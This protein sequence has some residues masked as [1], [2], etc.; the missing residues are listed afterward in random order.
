MY[1][2]DTIRAL[3]AAVKAGNLQGVVEMLAKGADFEA[4]DSFQVRPIHLAAG[5]GHLDIL[6]TLIERG[7]NV[8]AG[9]CIITPVFKRLEQGMTPLHFAARNFDPSVAH[10]LISA[11]ANVNAKTNCG[12]SPL[13]IAAQRGHSSVVKALVS[14]N[15][16]MNAI[17][18]GTLNPL[19]WAVREG[20]LDAVKILIRSGAEVDAK[21]CL[22]I[23]PLHY[24]AELWHVEVVKY[25][26]AKGAEVNAIDNRRWT[27]LHFAVDEDSTQIL[28]FSKGHLD[29]RV[30]ASKLNTTKV[31][32]ENGADV[33]AKG[34]KNETALYLAVKYGDPVVARC[35]LQNG[36]YYNGNTSM[37][38]IAALM[39]NENVNALFCATEKLFEAVKKG[40]CA[41]IEKCVQ[42]GAP[43]NS[44]SIK[45]ETPLTY[46]SWKGHLPVVNVLLKHGA[47]VNLSNSNGVTPLHYAAK[48]G[49]H[50]ILCVLL[51]HG[52]V[53]NATSKTGKKTPLH[54]AHE[55]GKQEVSETLKLIDRMFIRMSKKDETVLKELSELKD[56]NYAK[57]LA[58]KNCKNINQETLTQIAS[59]NGYEELCKMFCDL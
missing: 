44:R 24:A 41:E 50:E 36:A 34:S 39:R 32:I 57:L 33:N 5:W 56:I 42:E 40:K 22:Q 19:H 18:A 15:A 1:A 23:T 13:H 27:P 8:N 53:Y 35:L 28:L 31:L 9:A 20:N 58:V 48:F 14:A 30:H 16:D 51:Q 52:A 55:A 54:F 43:V 26:L 21:S 3:H 11:G 6:K 12:V 38:E 37:S 49:H 25:L 46:A 7:C 17:D 29:A 4:A 2:N 10:T 59:K 45:Y 47:R